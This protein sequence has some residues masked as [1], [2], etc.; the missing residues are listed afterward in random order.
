MGVTNSAPL[1]VRMQRVEMPKALKRRI[2]S[3]HLTAA[4]PPETISKTRFPTL[5]RTLKNL[6]EF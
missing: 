4:T 3:G 2:K 5:D 1:G 6:M